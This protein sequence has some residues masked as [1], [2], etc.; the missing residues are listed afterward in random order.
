MVNTYSLDPKDEHY[1]RG[2]TPIVVEV[3]DPARAAVEFAIQ[4]FRKSSLAPRFGVAVETENVTLVFYVVIDI[5]TG[6]CHAFR[7]FGAHQEKVEELYGQSQSGNQGN[8]PA[9]RP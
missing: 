6:N 3:D 4:C 9:V 7:D 1:I 5:E 2:G 8:Q